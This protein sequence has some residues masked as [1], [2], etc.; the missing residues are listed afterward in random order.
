MDEL[1]EGK[2]RAEEFIRELAK[3]SNHED[4]VGS[5]LW[6][7]EGSSANAVMALRIYKGNR[8]GLVELARSDVE[9]CVRAP[10]VLK[11]YEGDIAR[12]LADM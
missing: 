6:W 8:W 7:G 1:E 11:K 4:A 9:S 3:A 10:E 12:I 5:L 2:S